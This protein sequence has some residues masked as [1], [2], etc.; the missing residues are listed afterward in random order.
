M[1]IM[2]STIVEVSSEQNTFGTKGILGLGPSSLSTIHTTMENGNTRDS[3]FST[4][5]AS[6][7]S[8]ASFLDNFF[9]QHPSISPYIT[10]F[11]SR[12]SHYTSVPQHSS[13]LTIGEIV[14][15]FEAVLTAP[16]L[17]LEPETPWVGQQWTVLLDSWGL[18]VNGALVPL[19]QSVVEQSTSSDRTQLTVLLDTGFSFNQVPRVV[20]DMM[21]AGIEGAWFD[22]SGRDGLW[23]VPCAAEIELSL[24]FGGVEYPVH[25]LDAILDLNSG[26]GQSD[27]WCVGS[28]QPFM[29]DTANTT[30][31]ILGMAFLRSVYVLSYYGNLVSG[32]S[33][34]DVPYV[35]MLSTAPGK[36]R[37]HAEF[38]KERLGVDGDVKDGDEEDVR[39]EEM[40]NIMGA[41][42]AQS[43]AWEWRWLLLANIGVALFM[44]LGSGLSWIPR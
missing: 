42:I 20:A 37:I 26:S 2:R 31:M 1:L 43:P 9:Q 3:T 8:S 28:F 21:Y 40:E 15:G 13:A 19:P 27:G 17:L 25:P 10:T 7:A 36:G 32:R 44:A 30:D 41:S 23:H 4:S 38:V 12:S 5:S 11:L 16:K 29:F 14:P 33:E 18:R 22:E 6:S 39:L 34:D 24:S 35:Q